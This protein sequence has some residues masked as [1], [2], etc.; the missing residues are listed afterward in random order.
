[1]GIP[2]YFSH[3]IK[4][5]AYI[6]KKINNKNEFNNIYFD[7]NSIIYDALHVVEFKNKEQYEEDIIKQ[8]NLKLEE[9]IRL[10]KPNNIIYIAF[11][12]VAPIAKLKQQK[13]RRYKSW[14]TSQ[15]IPSDKKW[16]TLAITPGTNF[17]KKL[18]N[19]VKLYF[20]NK[21]KSQTLIVSG[22]DEPGEGEHK[23][24]EH[25]R[26][27]P[28]IHNDKT[29]VYGLDADLIML[30]LIHLPY[31]NDLLLFRETP[32]FIKSIDKSLDPNT[33]YSLH[34][35]SLAKAICLEIYNTDHESIIEK[36]VTDYIFLCFF[37]GND[38]IPHH[39]AINLRTNGLEILINAYKNA[40]YKDDFLIRKNI[41]NWKIFK[42]L[43]KNLENTEH[44][45]I[46]TNY[47]WKNK[48]EN[49]AK[50]HKY[51]KTKEEIL[52]AIPCMERNIEKYICPEASGW[53]KRYYQKLFHNDNIHTICIQYLSIL[54][55]NLKYYINGC[56][57][58]K[59]HFEFDYAPLFKD[60][61]RYIPYFNEELIH[62]NNT[63]AIHPYTQ[64]SYVLPKTSLD[65]LP[66][67][68]SSFITKHYPDFYRLDYEIQWSFC[69]YFWESHVEF[70]CLNIEK[71]NNEII[72]LNT[73]L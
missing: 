12:G 22:P 4:K 51:S 43:I 24:F 62:K 44:H 58:W 59:F 66:S 52:N 47:E 13:N 1:M 65:L 26:N 61:V 38:F 28:S 41:I 35:K 68:I 30:T 18:T 10:L 49:K 67:N 23:I 42:K 70:P 63:P 37:V 71:L 40:I 64:L 56:Y 33:L 39:P 15:L 48:L 31:C 45:D 20:K 34:I 54:E 7:S 53:E 3:I 36:G 25:I 50:K 9:L 6:L 2:S 19:G 32:E 11:D 55:W 21:F 17:M 73:I 5:Y 72:N 57:D 29:I 60:L 14:V 16:D 69:R 8:V 27:T 46:M